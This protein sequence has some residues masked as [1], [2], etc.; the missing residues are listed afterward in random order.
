MREQTKDNI[1]LQYPEELGFAF[2]TC[3]LI[4]SG[5]RL[6]RIGVTITGEDKKERVFFYS[7]NGKCYGDIKEYVQTF[8]WLSARNECY[9]ED[10]LRRERKNK[11]GNVAIF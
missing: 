3:L 11:N 1:T 9:S 8:L 10:R 4:A 6:E 2:N 5:E 7:L